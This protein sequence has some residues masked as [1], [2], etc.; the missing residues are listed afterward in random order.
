MLHLLQTVLAL[1][2]GLPGARLACML[3][4][5]QPEPQALAALRAAL[6]A[7]AHA[8]LPLLPLL[9][10]QTAVQMYTQM[11]FKLRDTAAE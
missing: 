7:L 5:L 6:P 2:E 11:E 4:L 1:Q 9:L 3:H 10:L 8:E